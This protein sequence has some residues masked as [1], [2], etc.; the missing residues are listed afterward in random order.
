MDPGAV[1]AAG[2]LVPLL[3]GI[4]L[5][6]W[7]MP[8]RREGAAALL[9]GLWNAASLVV[10]H[11]AARRFGWWRY[12]AAGGLFLGMPV[13]LY[14][15]WAVLWGP[16][17]VLGL[18]RLPLAAVMAI[19]AALDV[20]LMP[21]GHP[22]I[23]L[24]ERWLGGEI[25]ALVV[26]LL[27][28]QL[29]ARW[30]AED[31]RLGARVLMQAVLF[32]TLVLG[33]LPALILD[34][35]GTP[36]RLPRLSAPLVSI[37]LQLLA[38]DAALG[39]SALQE[40]YARGAGTPLPYDPPRQLVTSGLY[41]YVRNPMQVSM[42]ILFVGA[43]LLL[44]S[45]WVSAAGLVA[46]AYSA[47]LASWNE[48]EDLR[49]RFGSDWTEYRRAVR[50]W[51]PRFSPYARPQGRIYVATSCRP[52]WSVGEWLLKRKPVALDV[53]PAETHPE[54]D[55]E[56]ITYE[57]DGAPS[58]ESGVAAFARALEHVNFGLAL[59]GAL[60][61]L[62]VVRG[63]VQLLVDSSGGG[64]RAIPRTTHRG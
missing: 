9:G 16:V 15:G 38:L 6:F 44:A 48:D 30:T 27:P 43:G 61:R 14:L 41:R 64:P 11:A 42:S 7:K 62:P 52:C 46:A 3:V 56:R 40:F 5:W 33:V 63:V 23:R 45:W 49:A 28:S 24:G 36:L 59:A 51:W 57:C 47:G 32:V 31:R 18:A 19:M 26:A 12:D 37:A 20:V 34:L 4:A 10:V 50:A 53:L 60:L 25:V 55:L 29:L 22:V 39:L 35:T 58:P 13:D 21:L 17:A 8:G 2:L 1:R 54:R